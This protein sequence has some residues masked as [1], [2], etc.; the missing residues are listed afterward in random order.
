[1]SQDCG[2]LVRKHRDAVFVHS[3][4]LRQPGMLVSLLGILKSPPGQLLSGLMVL[5]LMGFRGAAMSVGGAIVQFG[6]PL[7]VLVMGSVF[8][9]FGHLKALYL[10]GLIAGFLREGVSVIRVLQRPLRMPNYRCEIP[11]FVVFRGSAVGPGR[12]FVLLGSKPVRLVHGLPS[13]RRRQHSSHVH[14]VDQSLTSP[15]CRV[16]TAL[17]DSYPL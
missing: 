17:D 5:F 9:T 7:M 4:P 6:G 11:F 8:V 10:P 13:F 3:V 1:M 14:G 15:E 12:K 2:I 16:W